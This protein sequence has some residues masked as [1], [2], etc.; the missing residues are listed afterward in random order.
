M[1]KK[2]LI[3]RFARMSIEDEHTRTQR[4]CDILMQHLRKNSK[5]RIIPE[6]KDLREGEKHE[7]K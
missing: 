5:S 2:Q 7:K 3:L 6:E 1:S 4:V